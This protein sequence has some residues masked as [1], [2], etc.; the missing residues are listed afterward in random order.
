MPRPRASETVEQV[1]N[2]V[3]RCGYLVGTKEVSQVLDLDQTWV[4]RILK[5]L[6]EEERIKQ[7]EINGTYAFIRPNQRNPYSFLAFLGLRADEWVRDARSKPDGADEAIVKN[8]HKIISM[9]SQDSE[10][11]D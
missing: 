11:E 7:I 10:Y 3:V 9:L 4:G 2:Y 6:A 5:R 8:L 1:Y